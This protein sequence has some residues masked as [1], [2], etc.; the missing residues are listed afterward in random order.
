MA[1]EE[2]KQQLD[3]IEAYA[4]IAAKRI[5]TIEEAAIVTGYTVSYIYRLTSTRQIP[6]ARSGNKLHF[7]KKELEEWLM[8]GRVKTEAEQQAYA[9]GYCIGSTH[10]NTPVRTRKTNRR[11]T[12]RQ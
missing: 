11:T 6:H 12:A 9:E 1:Q 4:A 5:L 8:R 2:I 10:R 7:D 3:R